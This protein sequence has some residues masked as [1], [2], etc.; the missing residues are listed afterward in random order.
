MNIPNL[1]AFQ[2][3]LRRRSYAPLLLI[4]FTTFCL[5]GFS[6]QACDFE[7]VK[8]DA[9]FDAGRLDACEMVTTGAIEETHQTHFILSV[10]PENTPI[11]PSP[12]YAFSAVAKGADHTISV[13]IVASDAKPRYT[14]KVSTDKQ[15]WTPID[16]HVDSE[17]LHFELALSSEPIYVAAQEII[18]NDD[19]QAWMQKDAIQSLFTIEQVGTSVQERPIYGM[20]ATQEQ[21][22]EWLLIVGR[23]H[24]PEIT[25]AIALF[26]FVEK[27][28]ANSELQQAFFKRFNVLVVPMINPDGVVA[29]NWRHNINGVDLNRDWGK[30]TQP[31]TTTTFNYF[32][33][34][35]KQDH[36]LVFALD[37]HSTQ[38]DIFYTMP[39]EYGLVPADFAQRWI[40]QLKE[41]RLGS[42]T[43]RERPGSSP[44]RGVFKQF[45]ADNFRVHSVTYEMGDNTERPLIKHIAHKSAEIMMQQMLATP[46]EAF[47][48]KAIDESVD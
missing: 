14:P 23:Q 43:V 44:G 36:R 18:V 26:A 4:I 38:Q 32:R 47:I 22:K 41:Q 20:V 1:T 19:Y 12:W 34:R 39:E 27:M 21:N 2:D 13:S 6:A 29:G 11:N 25:G 17:G 9:Q 7:R 33:S 30:F 3:T 28:S 8:F 10:N 40:E 31:E 45:I 15:H 16:F 5:T 35:L 48:P 37:F 24:P 42:F 46:A